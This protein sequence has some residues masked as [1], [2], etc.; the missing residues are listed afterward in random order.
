MPGLEIFTSL[1]AAMN[2][3][4]INPRTRLRKSL[5]VRVLVSLVHHFD[6]EN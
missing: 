5:K 3:G 1:I 4:R 2:Q 6:K